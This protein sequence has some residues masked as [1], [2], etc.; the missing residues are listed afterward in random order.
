MDEETADLTASGYDWV[1]PKCGAENKEVEVECSCTCT[2]CGIE[3]EIG[4]VNH[5]YH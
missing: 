1:C 4:N 5:A 3:F 2:A